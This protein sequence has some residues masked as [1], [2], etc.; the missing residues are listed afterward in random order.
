[1]A[2]GNTAGPQI[3]IDDSEIRLGGVNAKEPVALANKVLSEL[4]KLTQVLN[5]HVHPYG[6]TLPAIAPSSPPSSVAAK[7]VKAE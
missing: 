1:M 6:G 5:A 4:N 2:I 7:K 3:H